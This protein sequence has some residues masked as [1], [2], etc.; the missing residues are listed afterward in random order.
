MCRKPLCKLI[1]QIPCIIPFY[2]SGG[3]PPSESSN[4]LFCLVP[5]HIK[6]HFI[7][8]KADPRHRSYRVFPENSSTRFEGCGGESQLLHVKI[9][10][11]VKSLHS[12][13]KHHVPRTGS[14]V[15][16]TISWEA[17]V[18]LALGHYPEKEDMSPFQC[19][20]C[21]T[22]LCPFGP[23]DGCILSQKWC[24]RLENQASFSDSTSA[25]FT[26]LLGK[27][28][29]FFMNECFSYMCL[30]APRVCLVLV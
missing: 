24:M 5:L 19:F 3:S 23:E 16:M 1:Q 9:L 7:H 2:L 8:K 10:Y 20:Q 27:T 29:F 17:W 14:S 28:D 25:G 13:Q 18:S 22:Q 6:S 30:C 11:F 26:T 12:S 21:C 15:G 4:K